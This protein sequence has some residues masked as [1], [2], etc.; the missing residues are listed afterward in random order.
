MTHTKNLRRLAVAFFAG[1]T[2]EF[3]SVAWVLA[4]SRGHTLEVVAID[5]LCT[6]VTIA[7]LS[8]SFRDRR[9]AVCYVLGHGL[10]A[11][12]AMAFLAK[13]VA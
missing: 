4:A 2:V 5:V 7:G 8:E 12:L 10:G 11:A 3:L 13:A 6:T 1:A 9:S